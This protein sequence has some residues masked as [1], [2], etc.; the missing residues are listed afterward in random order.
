MLERKKEAVHLGDLI[1]EGGCDAIAAAELL[2][3]GKCPQPA[4]SRFRESRPWAGFAPEEVCMAGEE[5]SHCPPGKRL[6][7]SLLQSALHSSSPKSHFFHETF[8]EGLFPSWPG[9]GA[10][11]WGLGRAMHPIPM[12]HVFEGSFCLYSGKQCWYNYY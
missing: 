12:A 2:V 11:Q 6:A 5:C 7:P 3:L 9:L 1:Y 4:L 10:F 8:N